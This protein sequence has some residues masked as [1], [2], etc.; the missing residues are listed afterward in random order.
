[1]VGAARRRHLAATGR[2]ATIGGRSASRAGPF[3][4]A[5]AYARSEVSRISRPV[6]RPQRRHSAQSS[7]RLARPRRPGTSAARG[8]RLHEADGLLP[9]GEVP[10][11]ARRRSC[12]VSG[13]IPVRPGGSP[14]RLRPQRGKRRIHERRWLADSDSI[15]RTVK[16]TL[17]VQPLQADGDVRDGLAPEEQGRHDRVTLPGRTAGALTERRRRLE[18]LR[19]RRSSLLLIRTL[20][21]RELP[22]ESLKAAFGRPFSCP[23]RA[24][25]RA[26]PFDAW[27]ALCS[28]AARRRPPI[29]IACG[30][31]AVSTQWRAFRSD[32]SRLHARL[33]PSPPRAGRPRHADGRLHRLHAVPVRRRSGHQHPRPGRDAAAAPAAAQ[34][35]R[36]RQP[37]PGPVRAL[38]RQRRPRRVRPQPAPG[39]QGL[40]ADRRAAAGDARAVARWRR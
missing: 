32:P 1:M 3:D 17:P 5:G 22:I 37:V 38:R 6:S 16:A 25:M 4:V 34:R 35:P 28:H 33:R 30:H 8:L 14:R 29:A 10:D 23:R 9:R 19:T 39:T 11:G 7:F 12:S 18:G 20:A 27:R 24:G 26:I 15:D 13:I 40:V 36:P 2:R 21:S 31:S